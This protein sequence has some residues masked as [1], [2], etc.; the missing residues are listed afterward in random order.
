MDAS[1]RVDIITFQFQGSL[2]PICTLTWDLVY[3]GEDGNLSTGPSGP[4]TLPAATLNVNQV[5]A[6]TP[7]SG[8]IS[9]AGTFGTQNLTYT[10]T[11]ATS[12]TGVSGPASTGGLVRPVVPV[13]IADG[14]GIGPNSRLT[15]DQRRTLFSFFVY[16][17][18]PAGQGRLTQLGYAAL[19]GS[20]LETLR[21]G[22]RAN[23]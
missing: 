14:V 4:Q 12:F 17:L 11:T 3:T 10:G 5:P 9:V 21:Q 2:Y 19:P 22:F 18:S 7:S 20:W 8:A 23:F 13:W 1:P 6:G 15:A 16:V